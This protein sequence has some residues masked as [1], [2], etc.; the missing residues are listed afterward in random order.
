MSQPVTTQTVDPHTNSFG[1]TVGEVLGGIVKV[2]TNAGFGAL[3]AYAFSII[4]PIG[5]AI[6]GATA[7]VCRIVADKVLD[8]MPE[9]KTALKIAV[10]AVGFVATIAISLLVTTTLGFPITAI[11]A[12]GMTVGMIA[13]S[14]AVRWLARLCCTS[15][16]VVCGVGLA[17]AAIA[18]SSNGVAVR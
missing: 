7:A 14:I 6:F 3:A 17:A 2:G 11:G 15:L 18:A 16:V 10:W 1:S 4:H 8:S 5:G 13:T 9:N 12:V